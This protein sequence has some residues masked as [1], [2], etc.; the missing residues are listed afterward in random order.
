[1]RLRG[2][3]ESVGEVGAYYYPQTQQPSSARGLTCAI[4]TASVPSSV[5]AAVRGEIAHLDRE[6]PVFDVQTMAERMDR[7]LVSRRAPAVLA[8]W[9]GLVALF[10]SA[11][12]I[13]GV[14]TYLVTERTKEIGIRIALGSS[15]A[16]VFHLVLRE[17]LVLIASGCAIGAVGVAALSR[18]L[19]SQL[20][21]VHAGDPAVVS[22]AAAT[23]ALVALVA[24]TLPARRATRINPVIALDE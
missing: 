13:Y 19:E 18:R 16:D 3:V 8:T 7:S 9:F 22:L 6:L 10:L 2:L 15:A 24:C 14:L 23:L 5:A 20:F 1:V 21:G 12:G 11:I 4:R 17:G